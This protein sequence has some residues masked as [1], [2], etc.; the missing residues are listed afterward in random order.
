MPAKRIPQLD[1]KWQGVYPG[2]YLGNLWQTF[3]ID[4]ETNSGRARLANKMRRFST[5]DIIYK[6]ILSDADLTLRWWG[7]T[8]NTL[9][10]SA[11][12]NP[13]S[14]YADDTLASTPT[15]THDMI[16]HEAANG[17]DRLVVT[18]ATGIAIL[19]RTGAANV[20]TA[21]WWTGVGTLN[22]AALV[23]GYHPIARL[24]RL[25]AVGDT[26]NA[27]G[28]RRAVIHTIDENDNV[29]NSR[30]LFPA[31]YSIRLIIT[32]SDRFWF[33]LVPDRFGDDSAMRGQAMIIEW[34]G[35]SLTYRKEHFLAGVS[36]LTGFVVDDVPYFVDNLGFIYQYSGGGFK[37]VQRFPIYES[38]IQFDPRSRVA[39]QESGIDY[40]G[41]FVDRE[42][43]FFNVGAPIRSIVG[44]TDL[45]GGSRRMRSGVWIFN[46]KTK[47]LYH[48][49]GMG[50]HATAGTDVNYGDSPYNIPGGI[51]RAIGTVPDKQIIASANV[52]TGGT[53]W[54]T[55]SQAGIYQEIYGHNRA[56]NA[57]R[58]RGYFI[59]PY[60]PIEEIEAIWSGLWAK[61]K[62]LI[63]STED[64]IIVKWRTL[65]PLRDTDGNDDSPIQA[66]GTWVSTTTFTCAVPTGVA[67]GDEV[68]ILSGDNAGCLFN[69][70]TLSATP[71][72]STSITVTIG[73]A[74]PTSSTDTFLCRFDN[75]RSETSISSTSRGSQFVP[76]TRSATANSG[77]NNGEFIQLKIE[78]RGFAIEIDEIIPLFKN[79]T[80]IESR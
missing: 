51:M 7:L 65:D 78:L 48:N 64:R 40:Y 74:A 68:E 8:G 25:V 75:F 62:R 18:T 44:S 11:N 52:L 14:A 15:T 53:T 63:N 1:K 12:N 59:T 19:N 23:S 35:F 31:T 55:N 34:D 28:A 2:N 69:I 21:D 56:S 47:N 42:L 39:G 57:G 6:W 13:T 26:V 16:I 46:T 24:Q 41:S 45:T 70:T 32:T 60:I 37:E 27:A 43:V 80:K 38:N 17:E 29:V 5:T 4:L 54:R 67:V 61:F 36:P 22:Q 76:F 72:G 9:V 79:N 30:L 33:G 20:W 66:Q 71:D 58:N 50:E 3:N 73:E 77:T 10:I 49:M